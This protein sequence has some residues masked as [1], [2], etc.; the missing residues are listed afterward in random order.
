MA[1]SRHVCLFV[2]YSTSFC[3][4]SSGYGTLTPK[5]DLGKLITIFYALLGI[6]LMLLYMTT[7]GHIMGK[8]FKF[9]HTKLCR[10]LHQSDLIKRKSS[11]LQAK[12]PNFSIF[13]GQKS[14]LHSRK[15]CRL[16]AHGNFALKWNWKLIPPDIIML[17]KSTLNGWEAK[18]LSFLTK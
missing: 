18:V 3:L 12:R 13:F 9:T 11:K 5:T 17:Q 1:T 15:F 10:C 14:P 6:P 4:S 8:G 7:I 16:R 2:I